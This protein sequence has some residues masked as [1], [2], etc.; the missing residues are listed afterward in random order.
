MLPKFENED[1]ARL[2]KYLKD[3]KNSLLIAEQ[4]CEIN[5][6]SLKELND[7]IKSGFNLACEKGPLMDE[8][9]QGAVFIIDDII[10]N[11]EIAE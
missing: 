4:L 11:K 6:I 3:E 1:E 10:I 5:K 2:E 7:S 8:Q 9:M